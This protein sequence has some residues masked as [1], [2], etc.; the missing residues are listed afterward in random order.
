ES[1]A[2]QLFP[3]PSASS[4]NLN[5]LGMNPLMKASASSPIVQSPPQLQALPHPPRTVTAAPVLGQ[6]PSSL[7]SELAARKRAPE[8]T[9][10]QMEIIGPSD[11]KPV[12]LSVAESRPG[13]TV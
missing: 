10:S 3:V 6:F 12:P 4:S 1:R 2:S 11:K 7:I 13:E 9:E 5:T 8:M